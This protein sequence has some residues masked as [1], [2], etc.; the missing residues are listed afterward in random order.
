MNVLFGHRYDNDMFRS[1]TGICLLLFVGLASYSN[2]TLAEQEKT[3][4]EQQDEQLY[5]EITKE[6]NRGDTESGISKLNVLM[7]KYPDNPRYRNMLKFKQNSHIANL[8]KSAD[9]YRHDN[10]LIEAEKLYLKVLTIEPQQQRAK[11]A[12]VQLKQINHHAEI[13]K[14]AKGAIERQDEDTAKNRLR[15]VLAEDASQPEAR[16]LLEKIDMQQYQKMTSN[17]QIKSAFKKA[18]TLE[19]K[20]VPIKTVFE[21]IGK[22]GNI[23]FTFDQE[24][25]TDLNTSLFVRN[26]TIEDAI[27]IILTTN[28]LGKKDPE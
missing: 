5:N 2:V 11:E 26:T 18:I 15:Q 17:P 19:L 24:L 9:Q 28:Q 25:R 7:E 13:I 22:T 20:N 21:L 1:I 6:I 16:A 12:L 27:Q 8:L 10:Q 23:N 4:L 3:T 14:E